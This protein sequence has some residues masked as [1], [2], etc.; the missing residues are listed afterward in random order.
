MPL[1]NVETAPPI[2]VL[3]DVLQRF[4]TLEVVPLKPPSGKEVRGLP[5]NAEGCGYGAQIE[6][7]PAFDLCY[8]RKPKDAFALVSFTMEDICNSEKGFQFL[9]GEA[10]LDKSVGIF[11]FA[12]YMDDAPSSARFLRR[13]AMVLCHETFHLFGVRHCVY[14]KCLMNGSNHL[15]ESESRPFAL[16]PCC[17]RKMS[18]TLDQANLRPEQL[19][20]PSPFRALARDAAMLEFFEQHRL[21]EDA[22]FMRRCITSAGGQPPPSQ[23]PSVE[24]PSEPLVAQE[25]APH[26]QPP[27]VQPSA[28]RQ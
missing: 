28:C 10:Q 17:T 25:P 2:K 19:K 8:A 13:C 12:R 3:C 9:F 26:A 7:T 14:A 5:R 24:P 22:A 18:S 16:C 20:G 1:G 23:P 4:L 6:T 27:A 21:E 15:E 11:S